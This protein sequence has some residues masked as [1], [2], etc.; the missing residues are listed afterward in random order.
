VRW[1]WVLLL[2]TPRPRTVGD[3][4]ASVARRQR[5]RWEVWDST[6]AP[7]DADYVGGSDAEYVRKIH[8]WYLRGS[9]E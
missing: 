6:A 9:D 8:D 7:A 5:M 1:L 2:F 4:L 3:L